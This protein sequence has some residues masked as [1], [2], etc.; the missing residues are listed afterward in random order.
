MWVQP[1]FT[2]SLVQLV[3]V[4]GELAALDDFVVHLVVLASRLYQ[5]RLDFTQKRRSD[6][7]SVRIFRNGKEGILVPQGCEL[8]PRKFGE[9]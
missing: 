7:G 9:G 2:I 4:E 5:R 1:A 3:N 8:W 6:Y